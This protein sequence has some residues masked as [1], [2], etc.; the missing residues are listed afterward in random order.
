MNFLKILSVF[1]IFA[2]AAPSFA[3]TPPA[4][5]EH[6]A[7][8]VKKEKAIKHKKLSRARKKLKAGKHDV[9]ASSLHKDATEKEAPQ[10]Q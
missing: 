2:F 5:E 9:K 7:T 4:G 10:A 6:A 3:Q 1:T 8:E